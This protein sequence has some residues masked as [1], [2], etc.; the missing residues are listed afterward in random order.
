MVVDFWEN[1]NL[2]FY[3]IIFV[4]KHVRFKSLKLKNYGFFC[5]KFSKSSNSHLFTRCL[6]QF[7]SHTA[8]LIFSYWC[9]PFLEW[10]YTV[11][12]I[13]ASR[14]MRSA[15]QRGGAK[16]SP[17]GTLVSNIA[18]EGDITFDLIIPFIP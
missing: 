17:V 10:P 15:F 4:S 13:H 16:R 3:S 11:S 9:P 12:N 5:L 18:K 6:I 1:R 8:V 14:L 2:L 7:H